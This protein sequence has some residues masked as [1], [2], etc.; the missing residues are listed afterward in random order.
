MGY[1]LRIQICF[2]EDKKIHVTTPAD[3]DGWT[4]KTPTQ[5]IAT[6]STYGEELRATALRLST[7]GKGVL[8]ADESTGTI[9]KRLASIGLENTLEHRVA[10]RTLLFTASGWEEYVSGVI[11]FDETIRSTGKSDGVSFVEELTKRGVV[12]GIKVDAG[13]VALP[14]S[15]DETTTGG[16]DGLG[17]RCKEYYELGARFAKWRA[18]MNINPAR[19]FPSELAVRENANGLARYAS[20]CQANGLVPIVEPEILMDGSHSIEVCFETTKRVLDAV[21][22]ALRL[23]GVAMDSMILKPNM[24]TPGSSCGQDTTD[25]QIADMTV[26]ALRDTVPPSVPGILFLSGGQTE[27]QA[28]E[29]LRLMNTG[30]IARRPWTLSFS[31]GRALQ[32]SCLKAWGGKTENVAAAQEV[33]V[34]RAKANSEA[35]IAA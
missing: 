12:P 11:M 3:D 2:A 33:F 8:A 29:R 22:S 10:L 19:G 13:V 14:G 27:E 20:I 9:G 16:L 25:Q 21:F 31:Y 6:M 1:C 34:A 28:T 24:V 32:A 5:P 35:S 7:P 30:G 18:V 23:H 4:P 15:E 26:L 17:A